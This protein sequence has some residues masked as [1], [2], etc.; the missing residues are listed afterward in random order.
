MPLPRGEGG[1]TRLPCRPTEP[2]ADLRHLAGDGGGGYFVLD[3]ADDLGA[4]FAR[5]ADEL[6]RQYLLAFQTPERDGRVHELVVRV[7]HADMS[8]R[9]R[10]SYVAR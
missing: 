3:R 6:H 5:V 2:D 1:W 9:A 10:T 8:V 7:R 4:T